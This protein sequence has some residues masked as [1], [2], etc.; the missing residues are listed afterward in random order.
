MAVLGSPCPI[1]GSVV[2]DPMQVVLAVD[3]ETGRTVDAHPCY[4]A[5][6]LVAIVEEGPSADL[7][8]GL[9]A[10]TQQVAA[11]VGADVPDVPAVPDRPVLVGQY[12]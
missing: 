5:A 2:S 8:A 6:L 7:A 12:L 1:C 3:P 4:V 9:L 11:S 10:A